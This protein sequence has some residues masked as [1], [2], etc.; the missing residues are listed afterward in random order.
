[1]IF[2]IHILGDVPSPSLV[3]MISDARSLGD[4]VLIIPVAVLA[5]GLI[6]TYAAWRMSRAAIP[7]TP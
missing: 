2:T 4:A 3:G 5:G 6:W 7:A 1:S